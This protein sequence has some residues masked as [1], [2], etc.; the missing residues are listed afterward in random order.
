MNNSFTTNLCYTAR[1]SV[2]KYP[3]HATVSSNAVGVTAFV[4]YL[5]NH[6]VCPYVDR[7]T[8]EPRRHQ[9]KQYTCLL[10]A[11]DAADE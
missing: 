3:T 11:S 2:V 8:T 10:Y 5:T 1:I 9:S 6:G 7:G 4:Y